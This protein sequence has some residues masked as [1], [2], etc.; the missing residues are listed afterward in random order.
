MCDARAS[1]IGR[2]LKSLT[3]TGSPLA[4]MRSNRSWLERRQGHPVASHVSRDGTVLPEDLPLVTVVIPCYSRAHF[5]GEPIESMLCQSFRNFGMVVV[6]GGST[7][8][9]SGVASGYEAVAR[10]GEHQLR[11]RAYGTYIEGSYS[12]PALTI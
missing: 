4:E 3:Q 11:L 6:D 9:T 10:T 12:C 7:D 8:D 5:L 2:V 1:T